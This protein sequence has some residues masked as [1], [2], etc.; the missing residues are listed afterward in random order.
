MCV[1][2]PLD[3]GRH[4]WRALDG[5][6]P[7]A[8]RV[9]RGIAMDPVVAHMLEHALQRMLHL[10]RTRRLPV[11]SGQARAEDHV[12]RWA[13]LAR[14]GDE[15]VKV[16]QLVEPLVDANQRCQRSAS[17][18]SE[19]VALCRFGVCRK[20]GVRKD[21]EQALWFGLR[22]SAFEQLVH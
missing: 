4:G 14:F 6:Q 21:D 20:L 18:G 12:P 15:A 5:H 10:F 1:M 11:P 13:G 22:C 3:R 16:C 8:G 9:E 7:F 2:E 19:S 17:T